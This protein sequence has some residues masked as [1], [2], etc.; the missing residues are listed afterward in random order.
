MSTARPSTRLSLPARATREIVAEVR[1]RLDRAIAADPCVVV[2]DLAETAYADAHVL[3]A[4]VEAARA[5]DAVGGDVVLAAPRP[6][7][8]ILLELTRLH[9]VFDI[10]DTVE[11]ALRH[12][13]RPLAA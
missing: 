2:V 10:Y 4:L 6:S 9:T 13:A 8:A 3:A 11:D 5:A 12:T 1:A 7:V